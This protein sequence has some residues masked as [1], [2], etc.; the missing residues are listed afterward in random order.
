[1]RGYLQNEGLLYVADERVKRN[2]FL[3]KKADD[4]NLPTFEKVR[5]KLPVPVWE[6]HESAINCYFK[7]WQIAFGNLRKANVAA[8]FVS[9]YIDTAF[10]G[11]LFMWDSSFI[12]MFGKYGA[13]AFDFQKTLDNFYSHQHKDGFICREILEN[14]PGDQWARDDPASTG[15]NILPWAEWEY[16]LFSGD[17][18]RL[19]KV[20]DP[21]CA[22]HNWFRLHR[23]WQD[24]SYFSCGWACGMDNIPRQ[25]AGYNEEASHGFMSWID[26]CAQQYLSADLLIKIGAEIGRESETEE[27]KHERARL[28]KIINGKMWN[29]K[30]SFYCDKFRDGSLSN[31]KTVGSYWT[32]LAGFVPKNRVEKFIAH[33]QNENEFKRRTPIPALSADSPAYQ[34]DG[35]YWRGGVWA[36]TNYMVLRGLQKYDHTSAAYDIACEYLKTV[37]SVFEKTGTLYENYAPDF[38]KAGMPAKKDF[39]GWTGLAPISILLEFV[40]GIRGN[41]VRDTVV[42]E[43]R[44]ME[45]H[46]VMRY[47]FK[48]ANID[49]LYEG[50]FDENGFPIVKIGSDIPVNIEIRYGGKKKLYRDITKL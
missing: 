16:Y 28:K 43:I 27:L 47:P 7:A 37:V 5:E 6:G 50:E 46:G 22:Y 34:S 13:R 15:P 2:V 3:N 25:Q 8:G 4:G 23:S 11:N 21:L 36:P 20:F 9:D 49:L 1:M 31:V 30:M 17:K 29:A 33:L 42:W 48:N 35:G 10:N 12:V 18:E 24:G 45:K 44:R 32:L 39:V 38:R 19:K 14:Q 26:T 40:F 41:E